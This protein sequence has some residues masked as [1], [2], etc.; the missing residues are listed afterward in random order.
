MIGA[1]CDKDELRNM[2]VMI[3]RTAD[4][5]DDQIVARWGGKRAL[6]SV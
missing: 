2:V 6:D 4:E 3:V 5:Y 1:S